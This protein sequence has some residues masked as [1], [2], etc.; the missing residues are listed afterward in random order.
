MWVA[1]TTA[2]VVRRRLI[3]VSNVRLGG[4]EDHLWLEWTV[5]LTD[6][7]VMGTCASQIDFSV[8]WQTTGHHW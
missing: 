3:E 1:N 6:G 4:D 2:V 8:Q 7:F 5:T